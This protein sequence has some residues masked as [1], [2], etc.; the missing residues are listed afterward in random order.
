MIR[1][2]LP[3]PVL[4]GLLALIWLVLNQSLS[5][6]TVLLGV[7]LGLL[8]GRVFGLLR[9]PRAHISNYPPAARLLLRVAFDIVRS[10]F[11]VARLILRGD[12][13]VPSGFLAIPLTPA[14]HHCLELL[15]CILPPPPATP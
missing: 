1:R 13:Q 4:S 6:G 11:I 8:L 14:N 12:G 3:Y 7:V 10:T 2:W 9:P 15:R 5:P